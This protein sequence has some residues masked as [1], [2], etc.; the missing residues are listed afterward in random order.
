MALEEGAS[1]ASAQSCVSV[2]PLLRLEAARGRG[3]VIWL[4]E[5][6]TS[7]SDDQTGLGGGQELS[8]EGDLSGLGS[9]SVAEEAEPLV[10][11]VRLKLAG[12]DTRAQAETETLE[13]ASHR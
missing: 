6:V 2:Q 11:G 3:P 10:R 4:K 9:G 1:E 5:A 8:R 13:R 12:G 7:G